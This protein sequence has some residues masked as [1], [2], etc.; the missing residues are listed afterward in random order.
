MSATAFAGQYHAGNYAVNSLVAPV[1]ST[2]P[3]RG[4]PQRFTYMPWQKESCI[5]LF[6]PGRKIIL[7][8]NRLTVWVQY[9]HVN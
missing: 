9:N 4:K 6:K 8:G 1:F 5:K 3:Q 2:G 7:C